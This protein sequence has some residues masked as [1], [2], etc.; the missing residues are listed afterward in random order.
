[1]DSLSFD[2][3]PQARGIPAGAQVAQFGPGPPTQTQQLPPQMFTT[4]AQLLDLTDSKAFYLHLFA[5]I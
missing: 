5:K 1:M 2:E 4:A 3:G